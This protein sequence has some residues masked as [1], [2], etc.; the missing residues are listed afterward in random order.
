MSDPKVS[1][2]IPEFFALSLARAM[3]L[4]PLPV[5]VS[6]LRVLVARVL[7]CRPESI[8]FYLIDDFEDSVPEWVRHP[9]G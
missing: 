3:F 8:D 6:H 1:I 5:H 2:R 9:L 7:G 4:H